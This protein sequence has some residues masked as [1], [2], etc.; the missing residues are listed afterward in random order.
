MDLKHLVQSNCSITNFCDYSFS[1]WWEEPFLPNPASNSFPRLDSYPSRKVRNAVH[2]KIAELTTWSL[3]VAAE[4][5]WPHKGFR[6]E[7]FAKRTPRYKKRGQI[8]ANGFKILAESNF[9]FNMFS[10]HFFFSRWPCILHLK[11]SSGYV[12]FVQS[13]F[14]SSSTNAFLQKMVQVQP[15]SWLS[16]S[17]L[18]FWITLFPWLLKD[19]D[20]VVDLDHILEVLFL[21]DADKPLSTNYAWLVNCCCRKPPW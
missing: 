1:V 12:F 2:K 17:E 13:G 15:V 9:V 20:K 21:G 19:L 10:S 18:R 3:K 14:E 16:K 11:P 4:G 7:E 6:D 5:V 8:I